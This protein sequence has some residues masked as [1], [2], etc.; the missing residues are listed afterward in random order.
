MERKLKLA[1]L[2]AERFDSL[3]PALAACGRFTDAPATSTDV[4]GR[5]GVGVPSETT[6]DTVKSS[7]T[8]TVALVHQ[9]AGGAGATGVAWIDVDHGHAS[10][11]GFVR[12][13]LTQLS[14]RPTVQRGPLG[15]PNRDAFADPLR[16]F[17]GD[18][19]TG[20]LSLG[21]DAFAQCG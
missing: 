14:K 20:A 12:D 4:R 10:T 6:P 16:V 18:T 15:L 19:T 5:D 1:A 8:H 21:H 13:E 7:L 11:L 17:Q 9:P 3:D 2:A